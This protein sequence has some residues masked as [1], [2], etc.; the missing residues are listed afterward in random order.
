M[1]IQPKVEDFNISE[2]ENFNRSNQEPGSKSG[3]HQSLRSAPK[4]AFDVLVS[5]VALLFVLPFF[6]LLALMIKL[7]D[8]GDVFFVQKRIGAGGR[9]F[10]CIK[11]RTMVVDAQARLEHL[12]ATDMDARAE[13]M[14][15]QKLTKD[16]RIT[17]L[18]RFLRK[19]SLDELPQLWNILCGDMS[20]V[21]PRPIINNEVEK[22]GTHFEEYAAV[23]PGLT[24]LW[25]VSGRS[26][27]TYDERVELD[28]KY[29][30]EWSFLSDVAIVFKTVPAILM[31]KGAH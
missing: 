27:T 28:A 16:P 4:R 15:N 25:Q 31:S 10:N 1:S 22:Y 26:E 12:L 19:S 17:A 24:G 11:F 21:G 9:V 30:Q 2:V 7:Q 5:S 13:W 23:R 6:A 29:V 18:G 8:G 14:A 20:V 3:V